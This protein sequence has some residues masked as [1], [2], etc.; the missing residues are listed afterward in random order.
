MAN[1]LTAAEQAY[2]AAL[3]GCKRAAYAMHRA[4]DE[5]TQEQYAALKVRHVMSR[6]TLAAASASMGSSVNREEIESRVATMRISR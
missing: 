5:A 4:A 1:E 2:E 3:I 6:A